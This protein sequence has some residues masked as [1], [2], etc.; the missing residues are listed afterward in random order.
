[1]RHHARQI[2]LLHSLGDRLILRI[3]LIERTME[4]AFGKFHRQHTA[5]DKFPERRPA[6]WETTENL[7]AVH[8][9]EKRRPRASGFEQIRGP[10]P[11]PPSCQLRD[12]AHVLG[13]AGRA[14]G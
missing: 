1:V 11:K 13:N 10:W 12:R 9:P 2:L 8:K 5:N 7:D 3:S 4:E 6:L 14:S